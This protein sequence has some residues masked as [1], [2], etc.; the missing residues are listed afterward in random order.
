MDTVTHALLGAL[1]AQT[2]ATA[3]SRLTSGQRL[4]LGAAAGALPDIDFLGFPFAPLVF[5]A[6]WHQGLTHSVLLLP[7]WAALSAAVFVWLT[8]RR[9]ALAE[10]ALVAGLAIASHIV[11]DVITAYGTQVLAPLSDRRVA[12]D[13]VFVID[14]FF[15]AII[16]LALVVSHRAGARRVAIALTGLAVLATYVGGLAWLQ[17]QALDLGRSTAQAQAWNAGQVVALPQPFSPFHWAVIVVEEDRYH[18][19]WVNL[20]GHPPPVPDL[21]GLS[22]ARALAGSYRGRNELQWESW[23]RHGESPSER[24]LAASLWERPEFAPFRRF[25]VLPSLSRIDRHDPGTCVWFTDLRYDLPVL[26]ETFR[27]GFCRDDPH[28][29]WHLYRLRYFTEDRRQRL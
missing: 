21:P 7:L 1:V 24:E 4:T 27:Y 22:G 3:R 6:D 12:L 29:A 2:T 16:L 13:L 5:L 9:A 26:P 23:H 18:R 19:A 11:S 14:P 20:A 28:G 8:G 15:T 17:R 25:A 10:A